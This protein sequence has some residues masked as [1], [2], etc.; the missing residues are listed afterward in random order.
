LDG[1]FECGDGGI[2]KLLKWM[3]NLHQSAWDHK[4]LYSDSYLEDEQLL[5]SP[6]LRES[7]NMNMVGG[8]KL[9]FT[10]N[11]MERTHEPLHIVKLSFVH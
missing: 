10:F 5:I 9:K 1:R 4:I 8:S 7:K 2:F 11:F 6:L 3:Q